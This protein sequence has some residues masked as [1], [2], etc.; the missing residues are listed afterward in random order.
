MQIQK[1]SVVTL[2]YRVVDSDGNPVDEGAEPLVYLH[3]GYGGIFDVIE[4]ALHGK[5]QG[6][7]LE[8][9]LEP[10]DAFGDYDAELVL[11]E[12]RNLFPEN[13]EVGMQFERASEDGEDDELYTITDIA[14][15]KVVVDGNHP[16]AGIALHF[17]CTVTDVRPATQ[18]E[19]GHGHVHGPQGHHH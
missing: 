18:E 3:G 15:D 14:D 5:A 13:I 16:L 19:I 7:K 10:E 11:I 12:S 9:H 4:E 8:V 6:D 1:N 17:S 2:N